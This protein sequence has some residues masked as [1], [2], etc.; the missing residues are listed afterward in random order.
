MEEW[1]FWADQRTT[2]KMYIGKID[3]EMTMKL[4]KKVDRS[5]RQNSAETMNDVK[6]GDELNLCC[7]AP[8]DVNGMHND[9][10]DND[11]DDVVHSD[12]N[13]DM[14]TSSDEEMKAVRN[15]LQYPELCRS[16]DR[17]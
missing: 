7:Y 17:C 4:Q 14:M 3:K 11:D 16:L 12:D 2:R 10:D 15:T 6:M 1:N 5:K 9:Y 13:D 8:S